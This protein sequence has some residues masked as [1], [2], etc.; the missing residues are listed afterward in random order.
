MIINFINIPVFVVSTVIGLLIIYYIM[1]NEMR[2]IY[3]YPTPENIHLIQY[4]DNANMCF[5]YKETEI[6]CPKD[7]KQIFNYKPQIHD[8]APSH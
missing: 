2:N 3:V 1:N 8:N 6:T 5:K 4:K 7:E